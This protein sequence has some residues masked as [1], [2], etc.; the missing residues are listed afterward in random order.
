[1]RNGWRAGEVPFRDVEDSPGD[2][3]GVEEREADG[4]G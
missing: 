3:E 1:M 2:E 4:G